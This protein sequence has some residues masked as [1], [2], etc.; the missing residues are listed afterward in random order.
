M[1]YFSEAPLPPFSIPIVPISAFPVPQM[2]HYNP[3]YSTTPTLN[4]GTHFFVCND[5]HKNSKLRSPCDTI[6]QSVDSQ[7]KDKKL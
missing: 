2:N 5:Q 7:G 6:V 1:G 4:S 3:E